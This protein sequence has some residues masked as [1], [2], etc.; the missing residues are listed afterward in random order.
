MRAAKFYG[1]ILILINCLVLNFQASSQNNPGI[2]FKY[3]PL[4]MLNDRFSTYQPGI[5]IRSGCFSL[6]MVY[7]IKTGF[8]SQENLRKLID[9]RKYKIDIRRF[10][11]KDNIW[12]GE[13]GSKHRVHKFIELEYFNTDFQEIKFH[14]G[15]NDIEFKKA[16][17]YDTATFHSK[18]KGLVFLCGNYI[19]L[20]AHSN[21]IY[22]ELSYGLGV[23]FIDNSYYNVKGLKQS[24]FYPYQ[25][26]LIGP[27]MLL[28]GKRALLHLAANA[29]L[30]YRLN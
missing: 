18:N 10:I 7:G 24:E 25:E 2:I 17:T 4:A 6:N 26:M 23:N 14:Q 29:G 22:L 9:G 8:N 16:Y 12:D 27:E 20:S 3:Y 1:L 28:N 30:C 21:H 5:E 15:Y 19:N 13:K 11:G